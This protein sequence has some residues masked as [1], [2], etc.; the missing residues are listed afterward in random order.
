MSILGTITENDLGGR[1]KLLP[2]AKYRGTIESVTP[3]VP[4]GQ[5]TRIKIMVGRLTTPDGAGSFPNGGSGDYVIG[6]RKVFVDEWQDHPST[7]AAEI[8]QRRL[9]QLLVATGLVPKP[10]KN[11]SV[12]DPFNSFEEMASALEGRTFLFG[13]KQKQRKDAAGNVVYEEDG[14][15]PK[16]DVGISAFYAP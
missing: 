2:N 5:G 16:V 12:Q 3:N 9:R 7:Q 4:T 13:T 15:T 1:G 6:N 11:E 8:G 10:A 14:T